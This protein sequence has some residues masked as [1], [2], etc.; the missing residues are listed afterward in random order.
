[1]STEM[2][3]K[4]QASPEQNFTPVQTGLLQIKS[5]LC[6]TPGLVKDSGRDKEKLTLQRSLVD[7]AGTTTVPRFGHDFSRVSVHSAGPGM[8][9]TKLKI[10]KPGDLYEQ[11][12]DRVAE[13][14]MRME[15]PRVQRHPDEELVQKK[16]V[17]TP[18]IQR[19][20]EEEEEEEFLQTKELPGQSSEVTPALSSRI[21]SMRGGGQALSESVRAY[22][23]PRFGQDFSQVRAH[24]DSRAAETARAVNAR[25]FTVGEDV[26]FGNGEYA[27]E[28]DV[29]K[30]LLAH[31]LTHA[32]QQNRSRN[33]FRNSYGMDTG[34]KAHP[35]QGRAIV[36]RQVDSEQER[37]SKTTSLF[38]WEVGT[39]VTLDLALL[40]LEGTVV[41]RDM[42][43]DMLGLSIGVPI[44][45]KLGIFTDKKSGQ[46]S[47]R[48]KVF[49]DLGNLNLVP[50]PLPSDIEN[51]IEQS[52]GVDDKGR[53]LLKDV[54]LPIVGR[55]DLIFRADDTGFEI[56]KTFVV[57]V[58]G[59][60]IEKFISVGSIRGSRLTESSQIDSEGYLRAKGTRVESASE[61]LPF[62]GG[63]NLTISLLLG[64]MSQKFTIVLA[65]KQVALSGTLPLHLEMTAQDPARAET[66][67]AGGFGT[68]MAAALAE[69]TSQKRINV[70][71]SLLG[72]KK[73]NVEVPFTV[74]GSGVMLHLSSPIDMKVKLVP[75]KKQLQVL[76]P[77][78][79]GLQ[80]GSV[81]PLSS[82][83]VPGKAPWESFLPMLTTLGPGFPK[84]DFSTP[85][86]GLRV[87]SPAAFQWILKN[88]LR[89]RNTLDSLTP[90]V[91]PLV[92]AASRYLSLRTGI[93]VESLPTGVLVG[94]TLGLDVRAPLE[95]GTYFLN[96][97]FGLPVNLKEGSAK[98]ALRP[99]FYLD[100]AFATQDGKWAQMFRYQ[101]GQETPHAG[102]LMFNGQFD[103]NKLFE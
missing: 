33:G 84:F 38:P 42:D 24:A 29:G 14:V 57:T 67:N 13:Q 102:F 53:I 34:F 18:L 103:E 47:L 49:L 4:M 26:V 2:Q 46:Q 64:S 88:Q 85:L 69:M 96:F 6:N 43:L 62:L 11:E 73:D 7:Q 97:G 94:P 71:I 90:L 61:I 91:D 17:I 3:T 32:V 9:Q 31:E 79:R 100:L 25:A 12:A 37:L 36:Q 44:V 27:P 1:M 30:R 83:Q 77:G 89:K 23:E 101:V 56:G 78:F 76:L 65:G 60:K 68:I 51:K 5:A 41:K 28:S 15:E 16:P 81:S 75:R 52:I 35:L 98:P 59:N 10:N 48:P 54:N 50:I 8:I 63:S 82:L 70:S 80:V 99:S 86:G 40:K 87:D 21:Q 39:D 72:Y 95:H 74:E 66:A 92:D 93:E 45:I 19:Q 20:I 22:F 55:T 58:L